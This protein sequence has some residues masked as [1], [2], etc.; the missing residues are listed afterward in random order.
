MGIKLQG[1]FLGQGQKRNLVLL[2]GWGLN[3]H[4]WQSLH[5]LREDFHLHLL[6]L[7]GHGNSP[8]LDFTL[9]NISQCLIENIPKGSILLGWSMGGLLAQQ[10]AWQQP[11][12]FRGL[13]LINSTPQFVQDQDWP[14]ALSV[15]ELKNF[16]Q[17]LTDD[18]LGTLKRFL[19]LQALGEHGP[20][21]QV[22]QLQSAIEAGGKPKDSAL[23]GGLEI[24]LHSNLRP[25]L[26]QISLPSLIIHGKNDRLCPSG[27][28]EAMHHSLQQ[29]ELELL[30]GCA[31]AP[32]LSKSNLTMELI[33]VFAD[34]L[35]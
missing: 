20:K 10:L 8:E 2:H 15:A 18:Y 3:H 5:D 26:S 19:I 27:A 25:K 35:D 34:K 11:D 7:P 16:A 6:D 13:I 28:A 14:H 9:K 30:P 4:I 17:G 1:L 22:K 32:F 33:R 29:S 24:L 31:H 21:Q 23:T 12:H